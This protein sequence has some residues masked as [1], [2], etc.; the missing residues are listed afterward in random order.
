MRVEELRKL[1]CVD[2]RRVVWQMNV[3]KKLKRDNE[4]ICEGAR[5]SLI[6]KVIRN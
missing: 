2:E 5:K 4:I 1:P 3:Q 6:V